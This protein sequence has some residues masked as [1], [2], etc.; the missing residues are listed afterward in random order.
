MTGILAVTATLAA[1]ASA[2]PHFPSWPLRD[3]DLE[4]LKAG[5]MLSR[6][7]DV[8]PARGSTI[9]FFVKADVPTCYRQ[10]ANV[11]D[12][13]KYMP[14]LDAVRV[15]ADHGH[16]KVLE[17]KSQV[18]LIADFTLE[19]HFEPDKRIWWTKVKAPYK[20][21]DGEWAFA[22]AMGGTVLSY[23][24]IVETGMLV[25]NW[26]AAQ[27][28]KQG[29]YQLVRNVRSRIESGGRWVRPDYGQA[30]AAGFGDSAGSESK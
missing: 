8:A 6:D 13:P 25:P 27:F 23:T 28:Q 9:R 19:R 2:A 21:L 17:Y 3:Q 10:L 26:L 30:S 12:M 5:E 20:R 16:M 4:H 1:L 18:P 15:A 11:P 7:F 29:S 14:G 22:P 24:L